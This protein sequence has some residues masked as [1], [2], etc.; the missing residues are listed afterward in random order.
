MPAAELAGIDVEA[1]GVLGS[2]AGELRERV[3]A[4]RDW[5]SRF[6]AA[7]ELLARHGSMAALGGRGSGSPRDV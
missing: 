3:L 5:P 7:G 6:A 4:E 1:T 2:R